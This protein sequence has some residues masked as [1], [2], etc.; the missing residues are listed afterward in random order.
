MPESER[1]PILAAPSMEVFQPRSADLAVPF[2]FKLRDLSQD[3]GR[4]ALVQELSHSGGFYVEI[5]C[6]EGTVAFPRLQAALKAGG[7]N[8]LIDQG[9]ASRLKQPEFKT[10]YL[11]YLE[12]VTAE[13]LAKLLEPLG[14]EEP[15][16]DKD[17]KKPPVAQFSGNDP[18]L[19]LCPLTSEHRRKLGAFLGVDPRSAAASGKSS[20]HL[21][22]AMAY[23]PSA[24]RPQSAEVKRFLESRKAPR[25]GSLQVM[26]VLRGKAS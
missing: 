4:Q 5:L 9:A 6:R 14:Q 20:E 24:P 26:L 17:A 22:V 15:K 25:K 8:L 13:E 10:N 12:D 23:S 11:V 7:I 18:N 3:K 1:N 19:I 2:L 21:A 16:K